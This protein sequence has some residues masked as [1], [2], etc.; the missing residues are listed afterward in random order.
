M[1]FNN[2]E[3]EKKEIYFFGRVVLVSVQGLHKGIF[4]HSERH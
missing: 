3:R 1:K 2:K 4:G